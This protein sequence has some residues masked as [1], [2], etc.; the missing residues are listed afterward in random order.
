[1][2][3]D[4]AE[5]HRWLSR[6]AGDWTYEHEAVM[7]PGEPPM[8]ATG[9]ETVRLVG[10]LWAVAEGRGTMPDGNPATMVM[11]IGFDPRT[12]RFVGTWIGSMMTHL[13]VYDGALD[14]DRRTLSLE[15]DGPSFTDPT[16]L[17]RYRDAIEFVSDGHRTLT[18][19]VRGDDGAWTTFMTAHYRRTT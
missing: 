5:E 12:G 6:L 7:G 3:V 4:P 9:T 1:M 11:T 10:D 13:W 2:K 16:K 17:V 8:K 15:S 14:A 19:S 18:S